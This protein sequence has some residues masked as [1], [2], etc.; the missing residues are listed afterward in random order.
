[1]SRKVYL[2]IGA[3]KTGTTYVQDRLSLNAKNLARH[4]VHLPA[5]PLVDPALF[6][7]RAALD[8]LD[9]DWGGPAGHAEGGWPALVRKARRRSGTVVVSHEI[10]APAQPHQVAR[11]MRDLAG[12]E[13]H[14]VYSARDLARQVPA[15]WQESIKQGRSWTYA[16]YLNRMERG[17]VWFS[18]AFDLPRVLGTWGAGL[19][20]ERIQVVTVP[21]AGDQNRHG[22]PLWLRMCEAL[23]ID[24]AWAPLDSDRSNRSL[25]AAEVQVIRK[26]NRRMD[27][28]ARREATYDELIRQMLAQGELLKNESATVRLPPDRFEWA[29]D[30]AERWIEWI[31]GS[32]VHVVG[33]L[34][35]LRPVPL[36]DDEAYVDPDRVS[37]K[38]QLNAAL[39]ALA[40]M[41]HEAA[42]RHDPDKALAGRVR[43]GA[44]R[45]RD[46]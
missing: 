39:D 38:R 17:K 46:R 31:E 36:T 1:M 20:P 18:R 16:S 11:A 26:L 25:G 10:L 22:D 7:F 14:V 44:E 19:P 9:Q 35:D 41:T 2:H 40:A 32:G 45:L 6:H 34:E 30:R 24:P 15:A 29:A 42:R 27:R 12:A 8:L 23:G 28:A 13:I 43:A 5:A 33:D 3:P 21:Q 37:G 4:D